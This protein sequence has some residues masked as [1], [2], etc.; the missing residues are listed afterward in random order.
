ME[1]LTRCNTHHKIW[2]R[3]N[4][5]AGEETEEHDEGGDGETDEEAE[6]YEE[7]CDVE[8]REFEEEYWLKYFGRAMAWSTLQDRIQEIHKL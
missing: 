5:G 3:E 8:A 1:N 2:L 6:E 4:L 7:R